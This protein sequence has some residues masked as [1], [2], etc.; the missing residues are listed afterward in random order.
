MLRH[1]DGPFHINGKARRVEKAVVQPETG[2]TRAGDPMEHHAYA[3]SQIEAHQDRF[4]GCFV[5]NPLLD[6]DRTLTVMNELV[7]SGLY[8]AIKL[9]PSEHGY[10]PFK[11]RDRLDP[12]VSLAGELGVPIIVHQGDPPFAH[13]SQMA[14]IIE[15]FPQ[16]TFILAHFGT[17]RLVMADEAILVARHN[18]N[19]RLETGWGALPRLKEGVAAVGHERLIFA[20]DCPVQEIGS[21]LRTVEVL[22]WEPPLGIGLSPE[23]VEGIMGGNVASLLAADRQGTHVASTA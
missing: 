13:P 15:D 21:Q 11:A 17:Q 7:Q 2:P 4:V 6:H 1:M 3:L 23:A 10:M 9:H 18:P 20:S 8:R 12:I 19:V 22:G 14:P 16:V 5:A